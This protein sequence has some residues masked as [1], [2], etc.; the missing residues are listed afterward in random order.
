MQVHQFADDLIV[1]GKARTVL[2]KAECYYHEKRGGY[3]GRGGPP[4]PGPAR[5]F[6]GELA[7]YALA[8]CRSRVVALARRVH[9]FFPLQAAQT[10]GGAGRTFPQMGVELFH[11]GGGQFSVEIGVELCGPGCVGHDEIL[12]NFVLTVT[13]KSRRAR[14]SRDIT[15]PIGMASVEAISA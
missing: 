6:A 7:A 11:F 12:C 4:P 3:G 15:V 9:H 8:H 2:Q 5:P 14:E 13:R 10:L 1:A